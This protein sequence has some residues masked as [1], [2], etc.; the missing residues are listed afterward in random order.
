[1]ISH[2]HSVISK[3]KIPFGTMFSHSL[4][5]TKNIILCNS[6]KHMNK[7]FKRSRRSDEKYECQI[8]LLQFRNFCITYQEACIDIQHYDK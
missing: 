6:E 8:N 5:K 3:H 1:M 4:K 2:E 7:L